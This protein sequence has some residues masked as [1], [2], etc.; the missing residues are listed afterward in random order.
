MLTKSYES[1]VDSSEK[2]EYFKTDILEEI[3]CI[4]NQKPD[5]EKILDILVSSDV[6]SYKIVETDTAIS[7]EGQNLTGIKLVV[8]L[9]IKEKVTYV[10]NRVEQPV[11]AAHYENIKNVFVILPKKIDNED[12]CKLVKTGRLKVDCYIEAVEARQIDCRCI[13]KCISLLVNVK[14]VKRV[15]K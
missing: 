15:V 2:M 7:N 9:R 13:H 10:A 3:I 14:K 8:K 1:E 11:H 12:T 5:M 4:P 6:I